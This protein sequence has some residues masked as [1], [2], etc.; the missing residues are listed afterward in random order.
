M[1]HYDPRGC[2]VLLALLACAAIGAIAIILDWL[3]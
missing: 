2:Q 3:A 1:N